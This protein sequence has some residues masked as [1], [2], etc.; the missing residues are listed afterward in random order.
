M[1]KK[2][3]DNSFNKF[4]KRGGGPN[5]SAHNGARPLVLLWNGRV[6]E[7]KK[8]KETENDSAGRKRE[9]KTVKRNRELSERFSYPNSPLCM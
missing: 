6:K 7:S 9:R 4:K 8:C 2:K 3:K 1:D 5:Q